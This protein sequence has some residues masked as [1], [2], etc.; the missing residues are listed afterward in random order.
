MN[1]IALE[2]F[3]FVLYSGL[4]IHA[5]R[6]LTKSEALSPLLPGLLFASIVIHAAI[7]Y[8]N[9]DTPAG[10]NFGL[11]NIFAITTLIAMSIV[12]WNL[13][14]HQSN[15]LLLISLPVAAIS[16]L[17]VAL[18]E[19][20]AFISKRQSAYDIW[21]ILLGISSM[22]IL[23]LAALQSLL[24]LYIDNGLRN[25]PASIHPWLGPLKSM[26]RYLIQLL[27]IGFV[28]MTLSL[29]LTF[30]VSNE[31]LKD[32]ALHK[33][34]LTLLSWLI[35]AILLYGH[36]QRGWRG[37]FSAKWTLVGVFLLLL[38]YF[39]TKLVLEFILAS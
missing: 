12:L 25:H 18:F 11:F 32:Q 33:V 8:L 1:L 7:T 16:L 4:F 35:L 6:R 22:S 36:Y 13:I 34:V 24:V 15:A 2:V 14:R 23:L 30:W 27:S 38:G 21:H 10:Q 37:V 26:E 39:G 19:G 17:E 5:W 29:V 9:I 31:A 20:D 3:G 28:L